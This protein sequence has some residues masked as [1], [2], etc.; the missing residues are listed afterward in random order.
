[1]TFGLLCLCADLSWSEEG[2]TTELVG[3]QA[4][5]STSHLSSF[6]VLFDPVGE[7]ISGLHER[8]L[9]LLS[10][11]GAGLSLLGLALTILTYSLFR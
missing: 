2:V 1:M 9:S 6:S 11:I 3:G 4:V 10:Y 8:I 5:C 7:P